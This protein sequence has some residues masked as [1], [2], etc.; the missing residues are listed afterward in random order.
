LLG[1]S[2]LIPNGGL[3][4][5][6]LQ[7]KLYLGDIVVTDPRVLRIICL[8]E[9]HSCVH[10]LTVSIPRGLDSA[11]RNV[12]VGIT[13]SPA[14]PGSA[15]IT[16]LL[17]HI[18][19]RPVGLRPPEGVLRT[20]LDARLSNA[21]L[22]DNPLDIVVCAARRDVSL[23]VVTRRVELSHGVLELG[24]QHHHRVALAP[25]S[26][27]ALLG[28]IHIRKEHLVGLVYNI[29]GR[30][31][32]RQNARLGAEV[33]WTLPRWNVL[34]VVK[35]LQ[36]DEAARVSVG[37]LFDVVLDL[38]DMRRSSPPL[39]DAIILLRVHERRNVLLTSHG[40]QPRLVVVM[41]ALKILPVHWKGHHWRLA[42][43]RVL[44]RLRHLV[45]PLIISILLY[46]GVRV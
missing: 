31:S 45:L 21:R 19:H 27:V 44:V 33:L 8:V 43:L 13:S 1:E 5:L 38:E 26:A 36:G 34:I 24:W 2:R 4:T 40:A 16:R 29:F 39:V 25:L 9:D 11:Q 28:Q 32:L 37:P 18:R 22:T 17:P 14:G 20:S 12:V 10:A 6:L 7:I 41:S 15:A 35:G 42:I 23:R 3:W 46:Q 30:L